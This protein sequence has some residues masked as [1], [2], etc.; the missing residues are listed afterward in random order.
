MKAREDQAQ[1]QRF[2]GEGGLNRG[3]GGGGFGQQT[4]MGGYS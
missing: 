3:M 2:A 4:A 1:V